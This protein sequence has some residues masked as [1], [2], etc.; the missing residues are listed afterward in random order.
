MVLGGK[1]KTFFP[2]KKSFSLSYYPQSYPYSL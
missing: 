1:G 2:V